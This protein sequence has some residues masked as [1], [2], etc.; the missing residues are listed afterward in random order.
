MSLKINSGLFSDNFIDHYAVLC[1]TIDAEFKEIRQR[2]LQIVRILHPDSSHLLGDLEKEIANSLLSKL[3]NPAYQKLSGEKNRREYLSIL[4]QMGKRLAQE[5][6]SI[7]VETQSAK[8]LLAAANVSVSYQKA[9]AQIAET[10]FNDLQQAHKIIG[11]ISELNLVYLMRTS[12][13]KITKPPSNQ[14]H[15]PGQKL[16]STQT[17]PLKGESLTEKY[18]RRAQNLLEIDQ[19]SQATV[20][21]QDALK[22]EPRNSHCH[23][24]MAMVYLKQNQLKMAKI[25]FDN[26]LKL[27]PKDK[28]ALEWKPK[29]DKALGIT[30]SGSQGTSSSKNEEKQPDKS[31]KGGLFGGLFGGKKK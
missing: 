25:H 10:Q 30:N 3:V 11:E 24:L 26:A 27:N 12:G 18:L 14:P 15:N 19:L 8:E 4:S 28:I 5:A 13:R 1:V 29:V 31:G 21:L 16:P 17:L 23:S 9:I 20:E 22:L 6:A 7:K 2:Y